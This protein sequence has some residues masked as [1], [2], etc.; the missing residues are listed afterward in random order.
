MTIKE[1][2]NL[3]ENFCNYLVDKSIEFS[4]QFLD[5]FLEL[6]IIEGLFFI[7][8][9]S[10]CLWVVFRIFVGEEPEVDYSNY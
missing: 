4:L 8:L 10:L 6:S 9:F 5:W 3:Y 1:L 2:W 7:S